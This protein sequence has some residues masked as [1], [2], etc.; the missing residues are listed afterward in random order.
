MIASC[1]ARSAQS[2]YRGLGGEAVRLVLVGPT[3]HRL[4]FD[5]CPSFIIF[6]FSFER[7][8]PCFLLLCCDLWILETSQVLGF[9]FFVWSDYTPGLTFRF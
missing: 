1:V 7:F 2:I 3:C 5:R 4:V 6:L 9:T 8:V